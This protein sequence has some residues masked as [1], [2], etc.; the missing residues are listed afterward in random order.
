MLFLFAHRNIYYFSRIDT[1][2][3][4]IRIYVKLERKKS[5]SSK[6][7]TISR[8]ADTRDR[9]WIVFKIHPIY[10]KPESVYLIAEC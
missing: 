6:N 9:P 7:K 10:H 2:E 1:S 5:Y 8:R 3:F 4:I